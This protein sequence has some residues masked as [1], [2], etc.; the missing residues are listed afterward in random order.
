[1]RRKLLS[2]F[3]AA[4]LAIAGAVMLVS[5]VNGADERAAAG[6]RRVSVLVVREDVARGTPAD[7]LGTK[8]E[9]ERV[10]AKV[11]AEG[12]VSD[13]AAL[14][15]LVATTDL[16]AGEQVL[17]NR[18]AKPDSSVS[19]VR[20][21]A[22]GDLA[23]VPRLRLSVALDPERVVGGRLHAGDVVAVFASV[24]DPKQ[25][26]LILHQVPIVRVEE[27][28][29]SGGAASNGTLMVTLTLTEQQATTLVWGIEHGTIWL[30][31]EP[32]DA[33]SSSN[34]PVTDQSIF[35]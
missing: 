21:S 35:Q 11:R 24:D 29:G 31:L 3:V 5:Y 32:R 20:S 17:A 25:T 34:V 28:G 27:A 12:A 30:S 26:G 6:E 22:N 7:S 1:M 2:V 23:D 16:V 15:G 13:L 33:V 4:V 14:R 9:S 10:P 8:V 18:F 19:G